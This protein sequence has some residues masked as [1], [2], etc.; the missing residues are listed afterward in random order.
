MKKSTGTAAG[1][2]MLLIAFV[3]TQCSK[4]K[5]STLAAPS[6]IVT[7]RSNA[8]LGTYLADKNGRSLYFFSDDANGQNNCS[9]GCATLWPVYSAGNLTA[10]QIDAGLNFADFGSI[11]ISGGTQLTYKGWPLYTY[12]PNGT[13]EAAGQVSGD[14]VGGI[15]FLAKPDYSIMLA[16]WQLIGANG[17]HYNSDYTAGDGNSIYFTDAL[18]RT[19]YV[20]KKDSA[21]HNKFTKSDFSNNAT[22]PIYDTVTTLAVPSVLDKTQFT[23]TSVFGKNQL[24]Y[25]GWPLYF[26]GADST[27]RAKNKGITIGGIGTVWPVAV[28]TLPAPPH[29]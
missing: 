8:T 10:T 13:A 21:N 5:D 27:T 19:L 29:P 24:T 12:S 3:A 14:G 1:I 22:F 2:A 28:Q 26:Y 7:L 11:T 16:N 25:K 6:K 20:F 4:K 9:G 17:I 23:S 15:W 18:G